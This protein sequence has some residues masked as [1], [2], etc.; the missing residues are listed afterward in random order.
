MKYII[1]PLIVVFY[2]VE[3]A[4]EAIRDIFE[5]LRK[6]IETIILALEKLINEHSSPKN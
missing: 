3:M 1:W 4:I 5:I 6:P 2:L